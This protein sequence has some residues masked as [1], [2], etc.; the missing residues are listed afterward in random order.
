M[1]TIF[2]ASEVQYDERTDVR[3]PLPGAVKP[4]LLAWLNRQLETGKARVVG[5]ITGWGECTH[6]V[7]AGGRH[8]HVALTPDPGDLNYA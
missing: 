6:H 3:Q 4:A 7:R 5:P 1:P 2:L 8:F